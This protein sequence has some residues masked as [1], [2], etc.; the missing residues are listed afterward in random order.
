MI[1]IKVNIRDVKLESP[2]QLKIAIKIKGED[3]INN[4]FL[5]FLSIESFRCSSTSDNIFNDTEFIFNLFILFSSTASSSLS[6]LQLTEITA[7]LALYLY[8]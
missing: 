5:Y 7:I 3:D 2:K 8:S 1:K 6:Q 4:I